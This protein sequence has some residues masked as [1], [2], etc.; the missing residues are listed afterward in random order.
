ME[1]RINKKEFESINIPAGIRRAISISK[2]KKII[3]KRKKRK[4]KFERAFL[5]GEKPHSKGANFSRGNNFFI[6]RV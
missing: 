4:E 6:L 3:V 2:I 1:R 5:K